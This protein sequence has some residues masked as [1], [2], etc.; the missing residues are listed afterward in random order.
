MYPYIEKKKKKEFLLQIGNSLQNKREINFLKM[1]II[2]KVWNVLH[3]QLIVQ[4][5]MQLILQY[6]GHIFLNISKIYW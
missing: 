2:S 4:K 6:T 1:S 5:Y 3:I